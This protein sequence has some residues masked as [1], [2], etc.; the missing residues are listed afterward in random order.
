[1]C[2]SIYFL[3]TLRPSGEGRL[4]NRGGRRRQWPVESWVLPAGP[5]NATPGEERVRAPSLGR[6]FQNGSFAV[7]FL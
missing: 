3:E 6:T 1:M 4:I 7:L 2:A 5:S